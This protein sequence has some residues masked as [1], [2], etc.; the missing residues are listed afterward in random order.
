MSIKKPTEQHLAFR[1]AM[2]EA[3]RVHGAELDAVDLLAVCAH[4]VGQLIALQDQ[5]V[6]TREIAINIVFKN[7]EQGNMEA[8]NS[9]LNTSEENPQ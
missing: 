7:I 5:R 1:K 2:E 8:I 9:L 4:F 3:I 6:I